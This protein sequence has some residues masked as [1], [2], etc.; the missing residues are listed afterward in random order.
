MLRAFFR[1]PS[2]LVGLVTLALLVLVAVIAPAVLSEQARGFDVLQSNAAPSRAHLLGADALGRDILERIAV[3]TRLSVG[4]AF[5]ATLLGEAIGLPIGAGAALLSPRPRAIVLRTIDTMISFPGILLAIFIGAILGPGIYGAVIGVGI[6]SSFAKARVMSTLALSIGGRD[7]VAA[8]RVLG[9]RSP[10]LLLRY[11]LPN[12]AEPLIITTTVSISGAIVT[13]SGLSFLGLGVQPPD[14]DWGRML[15]DGVAGFYLSPAAALAPAVAIALTSLAFGFSGEALA[16]AMSPLLWTNEQRHDDRTRR[17]NSL[18]E[19]A[20]SESA[21]SS[22]ANA[23]SHNGV[24]EVSDLAVHFPGPAGSV[25]VVDGVSFSMSR[26]EIVGIVGESGSGK[27][28]MAMAI[29]QLV[30][31]P[32]TVSGVVKFNGADLGALGS[33]DRDALLGTGVAVVFQDPMSALNPALK[34]G[35]QLTEGAKIHRRLSHRAAMA[36]AIAELKEVRIPIPEQQLERHVHEL[37]GGM[38]QRVMIAMGLMNEPS[39]LI[40]DE[41]TTSLDVTIQAQIMDL[42]NQINIRH[43]TAII[44]ISHNISLVSQNCRRVLVMYAGRI[45]EDLMVDQLGR[46]SL[47][48]YTRALIAAVPDMGRARDTPLASI[49]GQPPDPANLPPGCAYQPRCPLAIA[50]C[51]TERPPLETRTDGARVACW[52]ANA[53]IG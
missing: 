36:L 4:L 52:V 15:T 1:A 11:V 13:L 31:Y 8:A 20:R 29:S 35:T 25:A 34:I 38:K 14:Y 18:A 28:M 17:S 19:P 10:R 43:G 22:A 26:G 23:A 32:G 16:R 39:L 40:A 9:V 51:A 47:H 53:D 21:P 45:V 37:S 49:G 2:A 5:L 41:P 12:I 6:A 24:L 7:F 44:L 42:L 3:A 48:P 50:R 46:A 27:T 30:P 33:R